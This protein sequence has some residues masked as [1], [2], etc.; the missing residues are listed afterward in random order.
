[1]KIISKIKNGEYLD[2]NLIS[3]TKSPNIFYMCINIF[4]YL[5]IIEKAKGFHF[6]AIK[7]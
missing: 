7:K 6:R 4:G 2:D 1:M 3:W 5:F